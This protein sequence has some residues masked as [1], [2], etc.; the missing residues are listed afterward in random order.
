MPIPIPTLRPRRN[1]HDGRA[2]A[3]LLAHP[4]LQRAAW[5]HRRQEVELV[6]AEKLPGVGAQLVPVRGAVFNALERVQAFAAEFVFVV[7]AVWLPFG[8]VGGRQPIV[9]TVRFVSHALVG[10]ESPSG[11][12]RRDQYPGIFDR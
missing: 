7:L 11:G 1:L 2:A 9:G 3:A 12:R 6:A 10:L 8:P 4:Q 5:T